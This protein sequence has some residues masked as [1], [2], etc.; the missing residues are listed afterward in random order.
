MECGQTE[1]KQPFQ[2]K[3]KLPFSVVD[4]DLSISL[5]A[6]TNKLKTCHYLQIVDGD[7]RFKQKWVTGGKLQNI[8]IFSL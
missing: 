3:I 5:L 4:A 7:L 1:G 2:K 6:G 8:D